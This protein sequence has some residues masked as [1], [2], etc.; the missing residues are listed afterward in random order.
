MTVP[1]DRLYHYLENLVDHDVL[2]YRWHPHGSKNLENL[3]PLKDIME[4]SGSSYCRSEL[5]FD[6]PIIAHD[7]EPLDL[8]YYN[9]Q[10]ICNAFAAIFS[11]PVS[12]MQRPDN[13]HIVKDLTHLHLRSVLHPSIH[14]TVLLHSE[15]GGRQLE[16]YKNLGYVTAYWWCH[17]VLARDWF[18]Y[19]QHDPQLGVLSHHKNKDFLI[20]GRAWSGTRE[21]RLLFF[22]LVANADLA[23][24][25]QASMA[26][27]ENDL[28]YLDHDFK[29]PNLTIS[30]NDLD[31]IFGNN[32]TDPTASADYDN[33]DYVT[34]YMEV[35][36]ET[37]FDDD[38]WHL[39]EKTLRP[40][41]CGKP[42]LLA[43]SPKSLQY[44]RSY[45]F[46]TFD[47]LID[48]S[49]D[50]I[51]DPVQRLNT[52]VREMQRIAGLS[53]SEKINL[54][55]QLQ[56]RTL[57]NQ[58]HFFSNQFYHTVTQEYRDNIATALDIAQSR[59]SLQ[60]S[61]Q[62]LR[63]ARAWKDKSWKECET[64]YKELLDMWS[65]TGKNPDQLSGR[66]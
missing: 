14:Q 45:G 10:H 26:S 55:K 57:F 64:F 40:I 52:M 24:H 15:V 22:E 32:T 63:A 2:I 17:A 42:F 25:C 30:R 50:L 1:L 46:Q 3:R 58:M 6:I 11:V 43:S 38:R 5:A 28:H 49:Y 18:R 20:Y 37:I 62:R 53:Q 4:G 65:A 19:A 41:A 60:W 23:G 27:H 36:L 56:Q 21:Y 48:E 9:R 44:L 47:P 51:S 16:L 8:F 33:R 7:Q 13:K 59:P 54:Y 12:D 61:V 66:S 34:T 29:N 35:V 31:R 39:T